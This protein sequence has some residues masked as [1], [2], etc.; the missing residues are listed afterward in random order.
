MKEWTFLV[1]Q[2]VGGTRSYC[3]GEIGT[4]IGESSFL[5]L[6]ILFPQI[7]LVVKDQTTYHHESPLGS[8]WSDQNQTQSVQYNKNKIEIDK[9]EA[10]NT[11]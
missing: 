5:F 1:K 6:T 3:A 9:F 4:V 11:K 8:L 10:E 2:W 7:N